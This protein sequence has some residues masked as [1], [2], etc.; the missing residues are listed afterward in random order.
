[1]ARKFIQLSNPSV[2][3][4]A[5]NVAHTLLMKYHP[6]IPWEMG[7]HDIIKQHAN[8]AFRH[9]VFNC[10]GF[11]SRPNFPVPHLSLGTV[12]HAANVSAFDPLASYSSQKVIWLAACNLAYTQDGIAFCKLIAQH[13]NSYVVASITGCPDVA[14]PAG[15]ILDPGD[16][17]PYIID[18]RGNPIGQPTFRALGGTL[19]FK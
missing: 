14:C 17:S 3:L 18:P 19:G 16:F 15:S 6:K 7:A 1:M 2:S 12:F 8:F 5:P 10:H 9:L 13:S 11:Y 4:N